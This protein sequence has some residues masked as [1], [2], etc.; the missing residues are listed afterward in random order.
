MFEALVNGVVTPA[1]AIA[2]SFH[3]LMGSNSE[4]L[5]V[6]V[7]LGIIIVP[8]GVVLY[9]LPEVVAFVSVAGGLGHLYMLPLS[10]LFPPLPSSHP[11]IYP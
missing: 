6:Y 7:I 11:Q 2:F 9:K 10:C 8:M 1:A 4:P 3:W 5:H